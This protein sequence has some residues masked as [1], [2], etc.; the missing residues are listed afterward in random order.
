MEY[1][2]GTPTKPY[3]KKYTGFDLSPIY[4][5]ED[6]I[7]AY[8]VQQKMDFK[9]EL[10]IYDDAI[11]VEGSM[12]NMLVQR[13]ASYIPTLI[14]F[15]ELRGSHEVCRPA[16]APVKLHDTF[17]FRS[18]TE[19]KTGVMEIREETRNFGM[20]GNMIFH[21]K[22]SFPYLLIDVGVEKPLVFFARKSVKE[23][24]LEK[25][26]KFIVDTMNRTGAGKE[27]Q[28]VW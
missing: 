8:D 19:M 20:V 18:I 13:G 5:S 9:T 14:G 23:E 15:R 10:L 28:D 3:I 22:T 26:L 2:K 1:Y 7:L 12:N 25:V 27:Q 21:P 16:P 24:E 11:R 17:Y 6:G 4:R